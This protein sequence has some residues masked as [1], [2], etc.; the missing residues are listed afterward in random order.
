MS[1]TSFRKSSIRKNASRSGKSQISAEVLEARQLLTTTFFLDF[2]TGFGADGFQTTA[3]AF[4][5]VH[6]G[7]QDTGSDLVGQVND[8]F[9]SSETMVGTDAV[10]LTRLNYDFDGDGDAGDVADASKMRA[11]VMSIVRRAFAPFDVD[12]RG[13]AAADLDD[14]N[15]ILNQNESATDGNND[16]YLF[17]TM[18]TTPRFTNA[19]G[20]V[21]INTR[22]FG[23]ASTRDLFSV[24]RANLNDEATLTFTDNILGATNGVPGT[25]DFNRNLAYRIA[26]TAVHEGLHTL[27][28]SHTAGPGGEAPGA[29]DETLDQRML[30]S[31]DAVRFASQTRET[32]NIITR[33]PLRHEHTATNLNNYN[34]LA[35]D[36]DIG[37]VDRNNNG[38]PDFAY[39]T[40]TG[41]HDRI[42]LTEQAD[43]SI[44]VRVQA[45]RNANMRGGD[46]IT[47]RT[48]TIQPGVDT[49]GRIVIDASVNN[50][51]VLVNSNVDL[52]VTIR[53]GDGNDRLYGG[54]GK[55]LIYGEAG[56]DSLFGNGG[57]DKLSGQA[58]NDVISG[59]AGNDWLMGHD[60]RD[61]LIGGTGAD[62]LYGG[63]DDDIL[64]GG[65]SK[66]ANS[67]TGLSRIR[68]EWTSNAAWLTR[69]GHVSGQLDG[70]LNG[71]LEFTDDTVTHDD[72]DDYLSG[73]DGRD[74][75]WK[76][77][78]D[79][80]ANW[81]P[82]EAL[83]SLLE[84]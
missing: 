67:H 65:S 21:G 10:V 36:A 3:A 11:S 46:L 77:G 12:V 82:N 73:G 45:Y 74:W 24:G 81:E 54:S 8:G 27:D 80:L 40:G 2:G 19:G 17:A 70:G 6:N 20:S 69:A 9:D 25:A 49:D 79:Q 39:V 62:R 13:A 76:S 14:V 4:R 35:N 66:W 61:I 16:A 63:A 29:A 18:A 30:A 43:G 48:Y 15:D 57:N 22:L 51:L 37:L 31:G 23:L 34:Q 41:A 68:D 26:Y 28:L 47:S 1:H 72:D 53:G 75:Y 44:R 55:D 42:T 7:T 83:N 78:G 60:G 71:G 32:N 38:I 5:D 59:G 58:G 52:K 64:I 33:F 56:H 50:D 84:L